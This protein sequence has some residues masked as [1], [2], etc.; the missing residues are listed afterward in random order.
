MSTAT[1]VII[2][3]YTTKGDAEAFLVYP[4]LFNRQGEWVGFVTP[5]REIYSVL[6]YYVGELMPDKRITRKRSMDDEKP[7]LKAPPKPQK[8]H[9]PASI[10]LPP[11][12]KE[13]PH[14]LI[15][16]LE[17]QPE[18]LHTIDSGEFREDMD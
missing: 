9:I 1:S 16:V 3:L 10:P 4:Y 17:D 18:R 11:M 12:M 14:S 7:R 8:I 2:P 5:Q 13:L 15:D 6:G